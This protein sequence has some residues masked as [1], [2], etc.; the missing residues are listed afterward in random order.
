MVWLITLND[1]VKCY[2]TERQK[3]ACVNALKSQNGTKLK[4]FFKNYYIL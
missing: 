3:Y 1:R 2:A 4:L